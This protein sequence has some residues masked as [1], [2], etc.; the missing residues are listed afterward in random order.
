MKKFIIFLFLFVLL[1]SLFC[2][3]QTDFTNNN[4]S[5]RNLY[6]K[7]WDKFVDSLP[8]DNYSKN[9]LKGISS[10]TGEEE[11]LFNNIEKSP[12]NDGV[13][14]FGNF[15]FNHQELF[16][17]EEKAEIL[18]NNVA[19]RPELFVVLGEN[20]ELFDVMNK[21]PELFASIFLDEQKLEN[22]ARKRKP[23]EGWVEKEWRHGEG[24]VPVNTLFNS[25]SQREENYTVQLWKEWGI[26]K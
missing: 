13:V 6:G 17:S 2:Y 7:G 25:T 23:F 11:I 4:D 10:Y 18:F 21:N 19:K 3:A 26:M 15:L 8:L 5:V 20:P 12:I 14:L 22:F 1:F 16:N 24:R 9:K